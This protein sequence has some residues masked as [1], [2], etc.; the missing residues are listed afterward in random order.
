MGER[1]VC[2]TVSQTNKRADKSNHD[3]RSFLIFR[4]GIPIAFSVTGN[5]N[6]NK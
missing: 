1:C 2:N 5:N 3:P 4:W 6:N